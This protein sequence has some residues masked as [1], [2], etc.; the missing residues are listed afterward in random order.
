MTEDLVANK[1][2]LIVMDDQLAAKISGLIQTYLISKKNGQL[3]VES[4][5]HERME[6]YREWLRD[7][8]LN[9]AEHNYTDSE[10]ADKFLEM[11]EHTYI[12]K[13]L[14]KLNME[15]NFKTAEDCI[16]VRKPFERIID[17][18]NDPNQDRMALYQELTNLSSEDKIKGIGQSMLTALINAK[19][20]DIPPINTPTK[21][22]FEA[23]GEPLDADLYECQCQI[24]EFTHDMIKLSDGA[25]NLDDANL[26]Y[27][28]IFNVEAGINYMERH[29]H[30]SYEKALE[31][32]SSTADG[33]AKPKR[34]MAKKLLSP[35]E[36]LAELRAELQEAHDQAKLGN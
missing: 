35:E 7:N 19:Y 23:I 36:R 14:N 28:Y 4:N 12:S 33:K 8:I 34:R 30:D 24:Y 31:K 25:L 1:A 16:K 15:R 27:W 5:F 18:I 21:E 9:Y 6:G 17:R 20:P 22:F 2:N 3:G 10:F 11:F 29:F 13:G 26:I 32:R